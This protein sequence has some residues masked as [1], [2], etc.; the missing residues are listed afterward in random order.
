M[1]HDLN[2]DLFVQAGSI[3]RAS[4]R[5]LGVCHLKSVSRIQEIVYKN[6]KF[7][8]LK[9]PLLTETVSAD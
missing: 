4:W 5:W 1:L 2:G 6:A 9:N 8:H 7:L 3:K